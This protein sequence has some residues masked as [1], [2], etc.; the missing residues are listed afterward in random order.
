MRFFVFMSFIIIFWGGHSKASPVKNGDGCCG[1]FRVKNSVPTDTTAPEFRNLSF[2]EYSFDVTNREQ[3][4]DITIVAFDAQSKPYSA[5]INLSPPDGIPSSHAKYVYFNNLNWKLHD[6]TNTYSNTYRLILNDTDAAGDWSASILSISD[7]YGNTENTGIDTSQLIK[8]GVNPVIQI[9]NPYDVDVT[10]PEVR[11]IEFSTTEVDVTSGAQLVTLT[12]TVYD[13]A[14]EID[15]FTFSLNSPFN[16]LN[17]LVSFNHI[18]PGWK[19]GPE[20]NTFVSTA[21]ITFDQ[22]DPSGE[23]T[24]VLQG[25]K[26]K[27]GNYLGYLSSEQLNNLGIFNTKV[28]VTNPTSVDTT[29]P[30]LLAV[31]LSSQQIDV[32]SNSQTIDV[33]VTMFDAESKIQSIGL[34]FIP[35]SGPFNSEYKYKFLDGRFWKKGKEANT[36]FRTFQVTFGLAVE[37][38]LWKVDI[39]SMSDS[40][41]NH[42]EALNYKELIRLGS[43][44]IL[45]VN[46]NDEDITDLTIS[47]EPIA[48]AEVRDT[49]RT[50]FNLSRNIIEKSISTI[51][52]EFS[53]SEQLAFNSLNYPSD[54]VKKADCTLLGSQNT[55]VLYMQSGWKTFDLTLGLDVN[56]TNAHTIQMDIIGDVLEL[57]YV[58][59]K[60]IQHIKTP[61][62]PATLGDFDGDGSADIGLRANDSGLIFIKDTLT[63]VVNKHVFGRLGDIPIAGD[64]DGDGIGDIALWRPSDNQGFALKSSNGSVLVAG[65]ENYSEGVPVPSDYDGDGITDFAQWSP[66]TGVWTIKYTNSG[67]MFQ[68]R[69]G[70]QP[71][72]IPVPADY[73]GDGIDDIAIRRLTNSTWYILQSSNGLIKKVR[74]GLQAT[75][76]PVPADY[77]GDGLA[78]IAVRRPSTSTWYILQSSNNKIRKVR[79]GLEKD[80]IPVVSDYDDDGKADIAIR[81]TSN[82]VWYILRSSDNKIQTKTFGTHSTL[83]PILAPILLRTAMSVKKDKDFEMKNSKASRHSQQPDFEYETQQLRLENS[84]YTDSQ[85]DTSVEFKGKSEL[86]D[87]HIQ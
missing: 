32:S 19:A 51:D 38:G 68:K 25:A 45:G 24:L 48:E 9:I 31:E 33:T 36:Y 52:L 4:L 82:Y 1:V 44:P 76:I 27:N 60:A 35:P 41:G 42:G 71:T 46:V 23:W 62:F 30:E 43:N 7:S 20:D 21:T 40:Q 5:V 34:A 65:F 15:Y 22:D 39:Y 69:F 72:D 78:D 74:F 17:K 59:N 66:D 87:L 86:S 57:N 55:C 63:G 73:D 11:G 67:S 3:W 18:K 49:I 54:S 8:L 12:V 6:E 83:V 70:L 85:S 80:D 75:D 29:A 61:N 81:R 64:F 77:D 37:R 2:S 28:K 84:Y 56:G 58:N 79:F 53:L 10:E 13:E 50:V 16:S 26:D 47:V 14:S